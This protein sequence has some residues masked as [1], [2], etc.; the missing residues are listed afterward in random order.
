MLGTICTTARASSARATGSLVFSNRSSM[1]STN[2]SAMV[3]PGCWR[4]ITH[5]DLLA[6]RPADRDE[7][8]VASLHRR[9][10]IAD[11]G[12]RRR[13][14]SAEQIEVSLPGIRLEVRV[15]NAVAQRRVRDHQSPAVERR[16]HA[17]PVGAIVRRHRLGSRASQRRMCGA[18]RW[19]SAGAPAVPAR[20]AGE[21]RTTGGS[22]RANRRAAALADRA[23]P[24]RRP[25]RWRLRRTWRKFAR[26]SRTLQV[27]NYAKYAHLVRPMDGGN[28]PM[29]SVLACALRPFA[30]RDDAR[31]FSHE[32]RRMRWSCHAS[33]NG[34]IKSRATMVYEPDTIWGRT[35]AGDGEVVALLAACG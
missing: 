24:R 6:G 34:R 12:Q 1:P 18:V 29:E 21:S 2:H 14:R 28:R 33:T 30:A 11:A 25:L 31:Q 26:P 9:A 20:P 7:V 27:V 35:V 4:A 10:Q 16:R 5:S 17:K 23:D 13:V 8:D 32:K 19:R 15:V 22:R 3:S